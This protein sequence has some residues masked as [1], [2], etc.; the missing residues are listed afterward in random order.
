MHKAVET[1][2][3][4]SAA[5]VA[6]HERFMRDRGGNSVNVIK[7]RFLD[8]PLVA[9]GAVVIAVILVVAAFAGAIVNLRR[10]WGNG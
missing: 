1:E 5:V 4:E 8:R 6:A 2:F 9:W 7:N 10:L 3:E